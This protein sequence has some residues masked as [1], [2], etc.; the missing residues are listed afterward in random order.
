MLFPSEHRGLGRLVVAAIAF[1]ILAP[2]ALFALPLAALLLASRPRTAPEFIALA[3]AGGVALWWLMAAGDLPDQLLRAAALFA[4]IVFTVTSLRTRAT[5]THRALHAVTVA[6]AG[7]AGLIVLLGTSWG[8]I[9]WWVAHRTGMTARGIIGMLWTATPSG[10]TGADSTAAEHSTLQQ[11]QTGLADLV[12]L[13]ADYYPA[14]VAA[15]LVVGLVL[16][17]AICQRVATRPIGIPLQPLRTFRFSE[18]L[19][20]AAV[21][22]LA[23]VLVPKLAAGKLA[24]ANMLVVVGALYA[25]RGF[26]VAAFG[27]TALG[28]GAFLIILFGLIFLFLMPIVLAGALVLGVVD[29]GFDL[30]ARWGTKSVG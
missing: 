29:A 5:V 30:R 22:G 14:I 24:A 17:T 15:Q 2:P 19:G 16:A 28:G 25:L 3:L 8:E 10:S 9:R 26:A 4:A 23:V 6:A 27:F 20:W 21:I 18:H 11:F 7:V 12:P 1:G 13:I